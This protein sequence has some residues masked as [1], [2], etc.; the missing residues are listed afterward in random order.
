ME[1]HDSFHASLK[2]HFLTK[3]S[4]YSDNDIGWNAVNILQ[5]SIYRTIY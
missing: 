1:V 3:Y 5:G 2:L 4:F